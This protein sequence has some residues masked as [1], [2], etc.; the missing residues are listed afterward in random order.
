M[1]EFERCLSHYL[2]SAG[3]G[4]WHVEWHMEG[5]SYNALILLRLPM[6]E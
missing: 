4:Q 1:E 2:D 5:N 3:I 6:F